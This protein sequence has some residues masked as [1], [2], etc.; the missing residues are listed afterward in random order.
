MR[1][2]IPHI[3]YS[4][5]E[6]SWIEERKEMPRRELHAEFCATFDRS[7]VSFNN[8]NNLCKRKG[9]LTGRDGRIKPGSVPPNKGRKMPFN[10]NSARTQF[11]KGHQPHNT[12][13][14]GH[15]RVN[16]QGYV[17]ISVDEKNPHTGFERRYVQK[18]RWLWEKLHGPVPE[19]MTLKCLDGDKTNTDP[20]N[21]EAIPRAMLP[22]LN[23]IYG[24]GYDDAPAELKPSIMAITK[25]EHKAREARADKKGGGS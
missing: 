1:T 8:F 15:E 13:Y 11:K 25:I 24:R 16:S 19:G 18:H 7:D 17:E 14:L 4:T 23:G 6:L 2:R 5:E 12:K 21:W 22:R 3:P 9:W 10:P 20:G